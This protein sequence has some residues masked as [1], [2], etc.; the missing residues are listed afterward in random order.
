MA[1]NVKVFKAIDLNFLN[2][3]LDSNHT[4]SQTAV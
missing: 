3:L 2:L 1:R 4:V